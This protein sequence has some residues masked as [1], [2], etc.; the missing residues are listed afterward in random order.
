M[1]PFLPGI[2]HIPAP[3]CY[4]CSLGLTY[5]HC[6][7]QCA[8]IIED[9]INF[10]TSREVAAFI[11]EPILGVGG[12]VPPPMEYFTEVKK[13]LDKYEV[14]LILDEVQ[15]GLGRTGKMWG[16]QT[17]NV[18]PDVITIAKALG[19]GWP[20]AA[21]VASDPIG[22]SFEKGDHFS[23]WGGNPVMCT[24][25]SATID[26]IVDHKLWENAR[27]VGSLLLK[28]LAELEENYEIVGE[29]RG[30]GLM[31]GIEIVKE[32]KS[33]EPAL[34]EC[35]EIRKLC[36]DNGLIVGVGGLWSNV[37]RIQP[38][39]TIKEEHVEQG[40]DILEMAVS[41]VNKQFK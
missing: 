11:A 39:L 22:N 8:K 25:A 34:E 37:L 28:Q 35:K 5:P 21:V 12:I 41:T 30:K 15:T 29:V 19:N 26:Y 38:P 40:I 9:I 31:V 6:K 2:I 16:C 20:I 1:G 14:L 36:H 4:R 23:T 17:Y 27:D 10:S 3:Y 13:I 24:A 33:K 18:K 32:K 7:L